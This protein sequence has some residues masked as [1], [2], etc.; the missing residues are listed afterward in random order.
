MFTGRIMNT[1]RLFSYAWSAVCVPEG[2]GGHDPE[3]YQAPERSTYHG[4]AVGDSVGLD[5]S[6]TSFGGRMGGLS[7]I[8]VDVYHLCTDVYVCKEQN[9]G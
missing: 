1:N 2:S 3:H 4:R 7:T 6:P 9:D 5:G 8:I